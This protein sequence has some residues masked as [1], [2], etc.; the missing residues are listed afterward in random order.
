MIGASLEAYLYDLE[1][2]DRAIEIVDTHDGGPLVADWARAEV[3]RRNGDPTP[4]RKLID[5]VIENRVERCVSPRFT[6]RDLYLVG[7]YDVHMELFATRVETRSG[8]SWVMDELRY[9]WPDYWEVLDD[10]A[11]AE[12]DESRE[13]QRKIREHRALVGRITE[14]M[15]L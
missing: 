4:L 5:D 10:W 7:D 11:M 6:A 2:F 9:Q 12:P 15:V 1:D 3:A 13:R 14:K 8:V